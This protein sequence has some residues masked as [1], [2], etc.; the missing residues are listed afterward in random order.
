[1]KQIF[2]ISAMILASPIAHADDAA[3]IAALKKLV[4]DLSARLDKME[5]RAA[6]EKATAGVP[7][8]V[9]G[10][11]KVTISGLM[12]TNVRLFAGQTAGFERSD[13]FQLRRANLT[14]ESEISKKLRAEIGLN[15]AKRL[16]LI[17]TPLAGSG[18]VD[19]RSTP[20]QTLELSY[21]LRRKNKDNRDYLD[22][23]QFSLP[24]GYEG[25][26]VSSS[27]L[28]TVDRALMFTQRD[29]FDGGYGSVHDTGLQ[30]RGVHGRFDYRFGIFNGLGERQNTTALSDAKA[31]VARLIYR[32]TQ[33]QGLKLGV[34]AALGNTRNTAPPGG[35]PGREVLS[36]RADRSIW[37]LLAAY[38]QRKWTLQSEYMQAVSQLEDVVGL[39]PAPG[40]S[41]ARREIQSYYGSAGYRFNRHIE[42]V[43][44]YDTFNFDRKLANAAAQ[45]FTLGLNY[46]LAGSDA[47]I[48]AN[49]VRRLGGV[50]I[51]TGNQFPSG[52]AHDYQ[53]D[54]TE[55]RVNF[56]CAF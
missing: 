1:M 15:F 49:L 10:G 28:Q 22:V 41:L 5:K 32:P 25:D 47:K 55:F 51:T 6:K 18:N 17:N 21:Q 36:N 30:L 33:I 20:L 34:S 54:R 3:E 45:D 8:R 12:Q 24:I 52:T 16:R 50:G 53:N 37:T 4:V 35:L 26:Q 13:T 39:P 43:M 14:L 23:G 19:Q 9:K 42:G 40:R 46:Y 29:A 2:F 11:E 56:Q 31:M 38:K 27:D 48:Q 44:R 7:V